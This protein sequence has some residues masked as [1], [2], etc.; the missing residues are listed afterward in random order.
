MTAAAPPLDR[1]RA[2]ADL[3]RVSICTDCEAAHVRAPLAQGQ[4][5][6]CLRCGAVLETRKPQA[7]ERAI[8]AALAMLALTAMAAAAPFLTLS[9]VGLRQSVSLLDAADTLRIGPAPVGALM[10]GVVVVLPAVRAL[11]HLY[12]LAPWRLGFGTPPGAAWAF[13]WSWRLRPW[14]MAEIFLIGTI[15]SLVKLPG[16]P[17]SRSAPRSGRWAAR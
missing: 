8:A 14:A 10:F 11:A 17:R 4:T 9:E 16:S 2:P 12:V 3:A 6:R 15:V 7:A 5:A 1:T 13:R